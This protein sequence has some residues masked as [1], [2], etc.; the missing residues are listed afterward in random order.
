MQNYIQQKRNDERSIQLILTTHSPNLGS[1]VDLENLLIC[2]G[3]SVFPMGR[4]YTK[5]KEED[6]SFLQRFL[7]VTKANLFFATGVILVEG[8]SEELILPVLAKKIG[9]DLVKNGVSIVNVGGIVF[10]RYSKIFQRTDNKELKIPVSIITDLDLKQEEVNLKEGNQVEEKK[11]TILE[12]YEGQSV[13]AFVSPQQTLEYC[14]ASSKLLRKIFYTSVLLAF[15]EHKDF[16][17]NKKVEKIDSMIEKIDLSF[18]VWSDKDIPETIYQQISGEAKIPDFG[19]TK[20]SKP[21]IAHFFA[22]LL[23][24]DDAINKE[25]L[26]KDNDIKYLI[27]A[28]KYASGE[29]ND[30]PGN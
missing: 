6:Y 19:I 4:Q 11:D 23:G 30:D 22:D 16:Q 15:K 12:K 5:L 29:K 17:T 10:L 28:I 21:T 26:E 14:L 1:K 9:Y 27:D 24:K 2:S 8:F 7:D 3:D 13:K 20:I 25:S 18:N